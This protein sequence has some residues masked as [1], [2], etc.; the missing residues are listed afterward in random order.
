M[1][2]NELEKALEGTWENNEKFY[3]DTKGLS[4]AEIIR[5]VENKYKD[6]ALHITN[7]NCSAALWAATGFE[8]PC[9]G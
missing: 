3:E 1:K 4:M 7:N 9:S 2:N 5:K 6:G 8:K